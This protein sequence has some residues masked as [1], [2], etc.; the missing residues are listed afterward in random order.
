MASSSTTTTMMNELDKKQTE[1]DR[2]DLLLAHQH[3]LSLQTL[4]TQSGFRVVALFFLQTNHSNN[5]NNMIATCRD[6]DGRPYLVGTNTESCWIGNSI[7]AERAVMTQL[8]WIPDAVVA[9]IVIV[10]D[11][12]NAIAPG[13]L[14][15]EF[16]SSSHGPISRKTRI[17]LGGTDCRLLLD[18]PVVC[19]DN[20]DED[21]E[22]EVSVGGK[23]EE[24]PQRQVKE[25][26]MEIVTTLQELYPYPSIYLQKPVSACIKFGKQY[27]QHCK[28]VM[29]T[30]L[31]DPCLQLWQVAKSYA[32]LDN[33]HPG[34]HPIQ[35][36]AAVLFEDGS[37]IGAHQVK[38][39]EYGCSLDAVSQLGR[40][41][42]Q[43]QRTENV[44]PVRIIQVDQFGI[45]HAPFAPARAF[46]VEQGFGPVQVIVCSQ[47]T[48]GDGGEEE[49]GGAQ[50]APGMTV[51]IVTV[52]DL[53]PASL[54]IG[55][56]HGS[57]SSSNGNPTRCCR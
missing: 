49:N 32:A 35:Y 5:S 51:Q 25:S 8:R 30:L 18:V 50:F 45:A 26:T 1:Q 14:C 4:P 41:I 23:N 12:P 29:E 19:G 11:A 24:Q 46:L 38:A 43:K 21:K 47:E 55:D 48:Y 36:G 2:S 31:D 9:K 37:I 34:L 7:C 27:S 56:L 57:S 44:T 42:L 6:D 20:K 22:D 53:T 16:M 15:R 13:M 28:T 54:D 39:T 10:T 40:D 17:V 52:H 3:R 33:Q